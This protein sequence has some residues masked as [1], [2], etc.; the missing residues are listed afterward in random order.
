MG[1]LGNNDNEEMATLHALMV[2]LPLALGAAGTWLATASA[3]AATWAIE[4]RI[5]VKPE[6]AVLHLGDYA[7]L[8]TLRIVAAIA[9]VLMLVFG[10][11]AIFRRRKKD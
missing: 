10:A 1:A 2:F 4:H 3:K 11:F 8:D 5:L 9:V 7:G 6:D